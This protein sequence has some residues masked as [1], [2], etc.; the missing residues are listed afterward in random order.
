MKDIFPSSMTGRLITTVVALVAIASIV[1]GV[2]S[3]IA[4][5]GY[6][7]HRLD[8][9]LKQSAERAHTFLERQ[10]GIG[11]PGLPDPGNFGGTRPPAGPGQGVGTLTAVLNSGGYRGWIITETGDQKP[12]TQSAVN[13]L[14]SVDAD[15]DIHEV[16]IPGAGDY[17]VLAL[18]TDVGTI[19]NGLPTRDADETARSL[20]WWSLL[21]AIVA[22]LLAA[23]IGRFL[24]RHQLRPLREVAATA[25]QVAG[26]PLSSG[27]VGETVRV[28]ANLTHPETEVG[29]V[30]T[31][32]NTLLGHVERSLDA[33]HHS[34]Q[35]LRQFIAD[36]SHEL[37]TPLA[38]IRGYAELARHTELE[39]PDSLRD[40]LGKVESEAGRMST[41]VD[42]LFLLA[43]LD[44][45]RPLTSH[46]VDISRLLLEA[47]NDARIV[48]PDHRWQL[49]IPEEAITV[50]GDEQRLH[51]VI[52][53]LL[54]NAHR[55][56]PPRTLVTVTLHAGN[57]TKIEV[58]DNGPGIPADLQ[59]T[60][61]ER[62][63]RGDSARTR[64]SGGAGL[65]MSLVA[66]IMHAHGGSAEVNSRP[67][68]TTFILT[69]PHVSKP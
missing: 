30:G 13:R 5:H 16:A 41:L 36:A 21:L 31:A 42:D 53:N 20:A 11:G 58:H 51:Q 40:T 35:R 23:A 69:F 15:E 52:T 27:E 24:I 54:S 44:S 18:E 68:D 26:L 34:E 9:Q 59:Q 39:D 4:I 65:G 48:A 67:R 22:T 64:E 55:H 32:L 45:G 28:P 7:T 49:Q 38:T 56:T 8:D 1:I 17:R 50:T 66:A 46:E 10:S 43:R 33:R 3:S 25:H 60:I 6:L 29:R 12:L 37:R 57:P 2:V 63:T 19:V 62:F 61:F 14:L 47:V